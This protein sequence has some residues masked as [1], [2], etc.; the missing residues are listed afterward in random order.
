MGAIGEVHLLE[1][2]LHSGTPASVDYVRPEDDVMDEAKDDY[3]AE[4]SEQ[5]HRVFATRG[6]DAQLRRLDAMRLFF[7]LQQELARRGHDQDA[8]DGE[9]T[10]DGGA[11]FLRRV[12][13]A[14][15]DENGD[16]DEEE[17]GDEDQTQER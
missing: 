4:L 14:G 13:R 2:V 9:E 3:H 17:D 8:E 11:A 6:A 10:A 5:E 7:F 15:E 16:E 12:P 1:S